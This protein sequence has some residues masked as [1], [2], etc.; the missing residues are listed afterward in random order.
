M[1]PKFIY[2]SWLLST[3][4]TIGSLYFSNILN[5]PPCTLCWW[6]R[7][8]LFPLVILFAVGF[9]KKDSNSFHYTFPLILVG[10]V[11]SFYHNLIY[12]GVIKSF[13]VCNA[14]LSCTSKQL[15]LL[16]FITIPLLS[17][18]A[19][20]ILAALTIYSIFNARKF[21][22]KNEKATIKKQFNRE[23]K[24][25]LGSVFAIISIAAGIY[26]F[27]QT[28]NIENISATA[29]PEYLVREF[30]HKTGPDDAKIKLVE[31]Y[32]PECEAC[33]A[34][35]PHVKEIVS[36]YKNDIQLTVR[37]A[38]Y[39]GNSE[40]AAKA[41]DAAGIQGKFWEFQELLF[42]NQHEWSHK[43]D[44]ATEYLIK[45]A[46]DLNLDISKFLADMNDIKRMET[47]SLDL[48]DGKKLDVQ[49]T[50]TI[51]MNGKKIESLNP[52]SLKEMIE[53]E[54]AKSKY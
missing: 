41:S 15:E 27:S 1:K 25:L 32:D 42:L 4:A 7:I 49:G 10:L 22:E 17:F 52:N 2:L 50:P 3:M 30:N 19:F 33:A 44:P 29:G 6:Q 21:Y 16:G 12:Y 9:V 43:K 38:L 35:A 39:H 24:I 34:L 28:D 5:L 11:I 47:I 53:N 36:R 8:C 13:T 26:Y 54:L 48:E 18:S 46:K 40:L 23:L 45:Y 51:F 31:F 37:F 20:S 14:G